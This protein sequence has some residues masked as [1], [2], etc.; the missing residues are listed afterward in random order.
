MRFLSLFGRLVPLLALA[1]CEVTFLSVSTD[2]RLEITVVTNGNSLDLDGYSVMVDGAQA[3]TVDANGA[4]TIGD[5][6]QGTHVVQL[7]GLAEN[8]VVQGENPRTIV[9]PN[10]GNFSVSFA[11]MCRPRRTI[12]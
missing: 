3:Q 12:S 7:S 10:G 2:G 9:V 4:I 5:I 11:V 6:S 1:A 8:C